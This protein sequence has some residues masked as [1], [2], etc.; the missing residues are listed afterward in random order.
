MPAKEKTLKIR[1]TRATWDHFHVAYARLRSLKD[2]E[3]EE[4]FLVEAMTAL[5]TAT[6]GHKV[7]F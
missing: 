2:Y 4:E 3:S 6:L 1:V 7:I 5:E